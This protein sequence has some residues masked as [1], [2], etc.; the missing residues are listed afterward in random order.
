MK[1]MVSM[2]GGWARFFPRES[3][4]SAAS[5]HPSGVIVH[6]PQSRIHPLPAATI[7]PWLDYNQ[8]NLF[9]VARAGG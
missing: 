6:V 8:V 7:F 1:W 3:V 5:V 2:D 9:K 4:K